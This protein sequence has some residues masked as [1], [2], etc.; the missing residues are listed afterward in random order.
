MLSISNYVEDKGE[1]LPFTEEIRQEILAEVAQLNEQGLRVLGVS[2]RSDLDADYEYTVEDESD[3]ILTG[4]LAFL[5]PPKPSAAPAIKALTEY[6]VATKILPNT[7]V[8]L[9]FVS[10][11]LTSLVSLYIGIGLVLN[12]G[13][14]PKKYQ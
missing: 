8:P 6:G 5:D 9:P 11:G 2:Y 3:M 13:L 4:Y 12:V 14:Q 7:G 1:I 10:Y